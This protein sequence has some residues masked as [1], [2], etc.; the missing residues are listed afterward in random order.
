MNPAREKYYRNLFRM[1]AAYDV[2]LGIAFTFFSA[3]AFAALG[4]D[5]R[6]P[7]FSGYVVL[8]G[9][10]VLVI[11]VA[12]YLI[13]RSDLRRNLDLILV[14][15]LYKL[16]YSA[17]VFYYWFTGNLPHLIFGALFGV[18]DLIFFILMAECYAFLRKAARA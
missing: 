4:I 14:G 11:G 3:R 1:A 18:A 17:T 12:Y 2:L 8:L 7:Q 13:S 5:D 9:A 6:L 10:F 16:A 15:V